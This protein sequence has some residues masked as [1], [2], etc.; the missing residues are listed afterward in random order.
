MKTLA[1]GCSSSSSSSS[2]NNNNNNNDTFYLYSTCHL[3]TA[4]NSALH[5]QS[6]KTLK[7]FFIF[8]SNEFYGKEIR[9]YN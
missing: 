1:E 4:S 6:N 5:R 8:V 7:R 2:S 9:N 3:I